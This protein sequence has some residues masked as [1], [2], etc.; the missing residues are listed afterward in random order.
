LRISVSIDDIVSNIPS[1]SLF[2]FRKNKIYIFENFN[3]SE[4][5]VKWRPLIMSELYICHP[6]P[7][8]GPL[9]GFITSNIEC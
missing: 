8:F 9:L 7:F 1:D 4:N 5:N 3:I 2:F 6:H